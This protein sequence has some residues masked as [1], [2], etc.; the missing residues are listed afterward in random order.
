MGE[1][2][3][4]AISEAPYQLALAPRGFYWFLLKKA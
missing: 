1:A 3:F 4:P 2:E